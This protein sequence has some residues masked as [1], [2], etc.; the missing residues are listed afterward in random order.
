VLEGLG[1]RPSPPRRA[2]ARGFTCWRWS[3]GGRSFWL[4]GDVAEDELAAFA[5]RLAASDR[6]PP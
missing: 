3:D 6:G 5:G 2:T 4:V 1:E